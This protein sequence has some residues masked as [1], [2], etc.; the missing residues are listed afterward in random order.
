MPLLGLFYNFQGNFCI[1]PIQDDLEEDEDDVGDEIDTAAEK[2]KQTVLAL[3]E[4]DDEQDQYLGLQALRLE[5]GL[6]PNRMIEVKVIVYVVK[7]SY[8]NT[9]HLVLACS[10]FFW[11]Q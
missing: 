3:T 6:P 7:V 10:S 5:R 11:R 2:I 1:Y 8:L 4:N 9:L